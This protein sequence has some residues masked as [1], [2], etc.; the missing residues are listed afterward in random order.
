MGTTF[1]LREWLLPFTPM[2]FRF[3][4]KIIACVWKVVWEPFLGRNEN[5][6]VTCSK[7][8]EEYA[9]I[10][11]GLVELRRFGTEQ[12]LNLFWQCWWVLSPWGPL[13]AW[14][15]VLRCWCQTKHGVCW[16]SASSAI[17]TGLCL[18][19]SVKEWWFWAG[20]HGGRN[21]KNSALAP[22]TLFFQRGMPLCSLS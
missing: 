11:H 20:E 18:G 12:W 5:V 2:H 8:E 4:R 19:A 13:R 21:G 17:R 15:L 1:F 14:W 9:L 16:V 3:R 10:L 6:Y 7:L 22:H